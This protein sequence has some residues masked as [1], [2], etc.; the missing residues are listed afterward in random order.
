MQLL[1]C[2]LCFVAGIIATLTT[3]VVWA[4]YLG[5]QERIRHAEAAKKEMEDAIIAIEAQQKEAAAALQS[6]IAELVKRRTQNQQVAPPAPSPVPMDPNVSAS[7]K[8]RLRKAVELTSKQS[9]INVRNGP[10]FVMAH[11]EL[12]LEKLA[13]LK[14]ILAD[15]YDPVITIRYN[16]GD[17]EMLLSAYIQSISK[18]LA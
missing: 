12:E 9:K 11:N 17:Q 7:V 16:T 14:T 6:S 15:G 10:E 13:V 2:L 3:L 4:W 1:I 5:M 18:G 8:E